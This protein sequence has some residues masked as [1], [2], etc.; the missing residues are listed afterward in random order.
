MSDKALPPHLR[1]KLHNDWIWPLNKISRGWNAAGPR[2]ERF[3]NDWRPWPPM[4]VEGKGVSRWEA[5]GGHSILHIPG[6]DKE[7]VQGQMVYGRS[8]LAIEMNPGHPEFL[9]AK[10]VYLPPVKE[11]RVW[12]IPDQSNPGKFIQMIDPDQYSPSALQKFSKEGWM[13]MYPYYHAEWAFNNRKE[14]KWLQNGAKGTSPE[15][16]VGFF[17]RGDRPDHVDLYYNTDR[18]VPIGFAGLKWE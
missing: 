11:A 1:G 12:D 8:W 7:R 15:D 13:K 5:A 16:T 17:R 10:D 6:L 18:C 3:Q 14:L 2:S 4:L 9:K